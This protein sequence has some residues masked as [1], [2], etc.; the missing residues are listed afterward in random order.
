VS[1]RVEE[2]PAGVPGLFGTYL[3]LRTMYVRIVGAGLAPLRDVDGRP[4]P[5]DVHP[6]AVHHLRR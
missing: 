2:D 1:G 3:L 4:E 6:R 5:P